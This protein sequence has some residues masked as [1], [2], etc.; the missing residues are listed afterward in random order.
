DQRVARPAAGRVL[1][2]PREIDG[3]PHVTGRVWMKAG[4]VENVDHIVLVL[5]RQVEE[6]LRH[7]V[8]SDVEHEILDLGRG[9]DVL[10][11]VQHTQDRCHRLDLRGLESD[12]DAAGVDAGQELARGR[13]REGGTVEEAHGLL[14]RG[15]RV[16]VEERAGIGGFDE[17]RRVEGAVAESRNARHLNGAEPSIPW[18]AGGVD[19]GG[20][21][22]AGLFDARWRNWSWAHQGR[23]WSSPRRWRD[24]YCTCLPRP[25]P[26]ACR[27]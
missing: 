27:W 21:R 15:E 26:A 3:L 2:Q 8:A 5:E 19:E 13:I 7:L 24:R 11:G 10:Q 22:V 9:P 25:S 6:G 14:D 1:G 18:V 17:R 16:V 20:G 23:G 12:P 4:A